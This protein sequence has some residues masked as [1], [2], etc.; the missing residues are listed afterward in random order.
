MWVQTETHVIDFMAP[1]FNEAVKGMGYPGTV[2][3]TV[4][5][6]PLNLVDRWFK[7]YPKKLDEL[8]LLND[9]GEIYKLTLRAPAISGAW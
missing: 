4:N 7:K 1:I 5:V 2:P 6:D 8:S 3:R 9:L